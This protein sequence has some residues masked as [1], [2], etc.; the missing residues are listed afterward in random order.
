MTVRRT[1]RPRAS[2]SADTTN[3]PTEPTLAVTELERQ[4][5]VTGRAPSWAPD[6]LATAGRENLDPVRIARYDDK[7]DGDAAGETAMLFELGL[8]EKPT[9]V[10]LGAGTGPVHAPGRQRT[11]RVVAVDISPTMLEHLAAKLERSGTRPRPSAMGGS[12]PSS[13]STS[14]T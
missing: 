7:E 2:S 11:G 6:E 3:Q 8:P 13:K 1:P 4:A 9:V 5:Q 14:V 12:A 10:D